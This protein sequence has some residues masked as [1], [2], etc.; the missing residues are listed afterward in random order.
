MFGGE[1]NGFFHLRSSLIKAF[2]T[3]P[4]ENDRKNFQKNPTKC[5]H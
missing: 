1:V 2:L 3:V 4:I 5:G